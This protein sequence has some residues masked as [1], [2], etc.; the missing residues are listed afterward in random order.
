[1]TIARQQLHRYVGAGIVSTCCHVVI[2]T[3]LINL[4]GSTQATANGIAFA[5]AAALSYQINARWSFSRKPTGTS[6]ARFLIVALTGQLL[7]LG[8]GSLMDRT[9][10]HYLLGIT[11]IVLIVTPLT[12][13]L[14]KYWTFRD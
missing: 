6:L 4:A 14:N 11:L 13:L 3:L 5:A 9:G 12:F 10:G 1:M 8:L 2:A 7:A